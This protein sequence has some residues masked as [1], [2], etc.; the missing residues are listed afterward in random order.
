MLYLNPVFGAT[1]VLITAVLVR[2]TRFLRAPIFDGISENISQF[3]IILVK[4]KIYF[5]DNYYFFFFVFVELYA[6]FAIYSPK[7][8]GLMF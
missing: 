7:A 2:Q 3:E 1:D 8:K 6:M 4:K 5:H